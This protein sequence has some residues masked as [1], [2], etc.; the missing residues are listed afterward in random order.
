MG[1]TREPTPVK[2]VVPMLAGSTALLDVAQQA[3]CD[4]LGPTD[5][6]S[7]DLAFDFTD[8]YAAEMG[9]P[10]LRRFVSMRA[11]MDPGDLA[12]LKL[13]TNA[14]ER[15]WSQGGRRAVN[16]DPGYLA[17]AKFVLATTK[18][19]AHRIY[20]GEGIYAEV[21]LL[22][23]GGAF[24]PLPWTYPDYCSAAYHRILGEMRALYMAQ[25]RATHP[26]GAATRRSG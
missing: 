5:Y 10:L 9:A 8:Y 21:T 12:R 18:D 22:Y 19:Y 6:V 24:E 4:A 25:L 11:L 7:D 26:P 16:L 23:R 2:L 20:L 13:R 14:L 1:T 15:A 17:G 3:V